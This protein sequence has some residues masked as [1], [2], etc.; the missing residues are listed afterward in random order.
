MAGEIFQLIKC[1]LYPRLYGPSAFPKHF[2]APS[3]SDLSMFL[4]DLPH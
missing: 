3:V 1:C 2:I 4:L